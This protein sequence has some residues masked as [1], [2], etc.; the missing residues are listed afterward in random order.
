MGI[1]IINM[2]NWMI[3]T[4]GNTVYLSGIADNHPKL[5]IN[6]YVSHTSKIEEVISYDGDILKVKT[7]N[8]IY[9]CPLKFLR[10]DF[11]NNKIDDV[12]ELQPELYEV[13]T[14]INELAD[15]NIDNTRKQSI[16]NM[17]ELGEKELK[18]KKD[19]E[20]N[21]LI[22]IAKNEENSIYLELSSIS[23][24]NTLAYNISGEAG[25]IEPIVHVGMFQD[26]VLYMQD[27]IVDFRYFPKGT[28]LEIYSW[29]DNI[30]KVIVKNMKNYDIKVDKQTI[31]AGETV[32]IDNNNYNCGLISPNCVDGSS[33]FFK[34]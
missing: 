26:S 4:Y 17:I 14:I 27:G 28:D 15:K 2:A 25:I 23:S 24:G 1:P 30:E 34:E 11:V 20:N 22:S 32:Q 3:H 21:R 18:H 13:I 29:S 5:G 33:I 8:S 7:H 6:I 9:I 10:K 19:T 16:L 31:K 12:N